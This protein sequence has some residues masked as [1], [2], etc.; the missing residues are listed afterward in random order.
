MQN[1]D[2][3]RDPRVVHLPVPGAAYS[4]TSPRD[5]RAAAQGRAQGRRAPGSPLRMRDA[6]AAGRSARWGGLRELA[7]RRQGCEFLLKPRADVIGQRRNS[8]LSGS[9]PVA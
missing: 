8:T 6:S 7:D 2:Y 3:L 1:T 4:I 9:G 5:A